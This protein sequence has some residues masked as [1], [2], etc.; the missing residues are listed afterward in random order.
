MFIYNKPLTKKKQHFALY[1][2]THT[3]NTNGVK[4]VVLSHRDSC[5]FT[6]KSIVKDI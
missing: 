2:K 3:M 5:F 4:G 6:L 1:C